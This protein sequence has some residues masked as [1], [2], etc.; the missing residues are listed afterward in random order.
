MKEPKLDKRKVCKYRYMYI[1]IHICIYRVGSVNGMVSS[2]WYLSLRSLSAIQMWNP[3]L[4]LCALDWV[5]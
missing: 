2:Q 1:H 3:H 4:G 5:H